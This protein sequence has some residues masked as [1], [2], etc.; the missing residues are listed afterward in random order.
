[1]IVNGSRWASVPAKQ[2]SKLKEMA[3]F[4]RGLFE[5]PVSSFH[6]GEYYA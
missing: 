2:T 4:T 6:K 5:E 1:M 3:G